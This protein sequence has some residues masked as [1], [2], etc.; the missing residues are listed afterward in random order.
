MGVSNCW[1]LI[2][3]FLERFGLTL[4][5]DAQHAI[6]NVKFKISNPSPGHFF[7]KTYKY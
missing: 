3:L 2:L 6:A 4:L 1:G 7:V 5:D